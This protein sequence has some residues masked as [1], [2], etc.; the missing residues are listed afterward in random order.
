[1]CNTF[2]PDRLCSLSLGCVVPYSVVLLEQL[3]HVVP[4][5]GPRNEHYHRWIHKQYLR[6]G[7]RSLAVWCRIFYQENQ[8]VPVAPPLGGAPIH[9]WGWP[10]DLLPSP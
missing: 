1:M 9:T 3:L 4:T 6:C 5:S 2:I 8:S 7:V 10:D